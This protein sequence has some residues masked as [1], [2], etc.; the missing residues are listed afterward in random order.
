MRVS[1][2]RRRV[3]EKIAQVTA[4]GDEETTARVMEF[5]RALLLALASHAPDWE[6]DL[7]GMTV[8][9]G[10]AARILGMHQEY[11]RELV[12]K[13]RL[14]ASKDNGEFH[15]PLSEVISFQTRSPRLKRRTHIHGPWTRGA[16]RGGPELPTFGLWELWRRPTEE[17]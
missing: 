7:E 16:V 5:S 9:T 4:S 12:R 1:E 11:V 15:I 2:L 13:R 3:V 6:V 17:S 14:N 8:K 10:T